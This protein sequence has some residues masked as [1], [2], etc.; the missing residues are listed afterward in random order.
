MKAQTQAQRRQLAA[1]IHQQGVERLFITLGV[2]G[3]FYS[4][5][6]AQGIEK[7]PII[8]GVM[9][10]AGGAGD[11]F[12]AGLAY[13]W[14]KDWSLSKSLRF[15]LAAAQVTVS[16]NAT[17]SPALSLAAVNRIYKS[18]HAG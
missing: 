16:D 8:K 7:P 12:L 15:S 4:A 11:A 1:W 17:S 6:D 2:R 14:L 5:G 10:N 9:S 3:V 18:Q 13:A